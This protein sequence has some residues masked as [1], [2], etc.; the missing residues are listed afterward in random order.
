VA[1]VRRSDEDWRLAPASAE[2]VVPVEKRVLL[3]LPAAVRRSMEKPAP[4]VLAVVVLSGFKV[5]THERHVL[6]MFRQ[7][8]WSGFQ[9]QN[10]SAARRIGNE[11]MFRNDGPE[12]PAADDD[13]IEV[14]RSSADALAHAI[15][16]LLQGIAQESAHVI[17]CEGSGFRRQRH[18]IDSVVTKRR[19][20]FLRWRPFVRLELPVDENQA[21]VPIW[22]EILR[23]RS[24][25]FQRKKQRRCTNRRSFAAFEVQFE[26]CGAVLNL[27]P[28]FVRSMSPRSGSC[29]NYWIKPSVYQSRSCL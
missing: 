21:S 13:D 18:G 19:Q 15:A 28:S 24:L 10:A 26:I 4:E 6:H 20:K 12:R 5:G 29:T 22:G 17:E 25:I 2:L 8:E 1:R 9:H 11:E 23:E 14:A 27:S 7:H 3:M 16:C